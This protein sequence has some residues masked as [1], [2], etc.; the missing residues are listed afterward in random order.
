LGIE[1]NPVYVRLAEERL[2][3]DVERDGPEARAA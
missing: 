3:L 1:L 2:G